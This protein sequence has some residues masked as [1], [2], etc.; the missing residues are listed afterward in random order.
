ME[1]LDRDKIQF[2]QG[3]GFLVVSTIDATGSIHNA[4][5]GLVKVDHDGQV[6]YMLDLYEGRTYSNLKRNSHISVTAVDEH[7]FSGVCVKGIAKIIPQENIPLEIIKAW[8]DKIASRI[9]QRL[10]KNVR[11]EK[12]HPHHPEAVLPKPK[13][14]I[15]IEIKEITDLTPQHLKQRGQ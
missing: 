15:A 7:K 3:Q 6:L 14:I 9:T 8:E 1:K 5:K 12:G 10:L 13:Y 11:E 2:L 4:C